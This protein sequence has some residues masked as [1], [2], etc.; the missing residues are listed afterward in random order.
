VLDQG[1]IQF[2]GEVEALR[3]NHEVQALYLGVT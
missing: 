3:R 2:E 1:R